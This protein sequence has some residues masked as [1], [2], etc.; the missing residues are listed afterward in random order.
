MSGRATPAAGAA[1]PGN[2]RQS[3]EFLSKLTGIFH[4]DVR[5]YNKN[6]DKYA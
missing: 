4:K 5:M 6:R 3:I 2:A 1:S